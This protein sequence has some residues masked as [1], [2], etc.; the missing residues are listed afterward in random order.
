MTERDRENLMFQISYALLA[1]TSS[2]LHCLWTARRGDCRGIKKKRGQFLIQS[3][4]AGAILVGCPSISSRQEAACQIASSL[5]D[6]ATRVVEPVVRVCAPCRAGTIAGFQSTALFVNS[7]FKKHCNSSRQSPLHLLVSFS[8]VFQFA[9]FDVLCPVFFL[10]FLTWSAF[11][12]LERYAAL[13]VTSLART[14]FSFRFTGRL[15]CFIVFSHLVSPGL[16]FF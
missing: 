3:M 4:F 2:N 6:S 13:L 11:G 14:F 16:F 7:F 15:T 9:S 12:V 8:P 1:C 5:T 10:L